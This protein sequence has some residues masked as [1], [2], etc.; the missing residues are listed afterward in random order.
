MSAVLAGDIGAR[1]DLQM[2]HGSVLGP[3]VMDFANDDGTPIVFV[4]TIDTSLVAKA[5]LRE[6]P[7]T[8][9]DLVVTIDAMPGRLV[10]GITDEVA[11]SLPRP[12]TVASPPKVLDWSLEVNFGD[13][14]P[15]QPL[16]HGQLKVHANATEAAV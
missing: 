14:Q 10:L 13:T 11:E 2:R 12:A 3:V 15:D 4:D 16:F 8:M 9:F 6:A 7:F 5:R 1:L